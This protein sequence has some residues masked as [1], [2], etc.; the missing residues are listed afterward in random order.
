MD[1]SS[2][3]EVV[4]RLARH[5]LPHD[6]LVILLLH[7]EPDVPS[8][9]CL[10][11]AFCHLCHPVGPSVE[12]GRSWPPTGFSFSPVLLANQ[13]A[14][15]EDLAATAA[16]HPGDQ[17]LLDVG[18]AALIVPIYVPPRVL[19]G[20]VFMSQTPS[21]FSAGDVPPA[22]PVAGLLA[23]ALEHQRLCQQSKALAVA[24]ERNRLARDIHDIQAQSLT[25]IIMNL[26]SLKPY[27][28]RHS[29]AEAQMLAE[30][31]ALARA[32]LEEARRSI[33]RLSPTPLEYQSLRDALTQELARLAR[34][35]GLATQCY[36]H[37]EERPLAPDQ[38]TALFRVA[39]EAFQNIYKHAAARHVILGLAF[40]ADAVVLTIE[41]D[42]IG[43]VA[44]ARVPDEQGGFGLLSMAA[45]TRSLGGQLEV[46]SRPGHGTAVRA[47]LPYVRPRPTTA[48]VVLD[49]GEM[50]ATPAPLPCP[51]RVLVVD[52]HTVARQGIRR[53][54]DGHADI[55]VIG[56]AGDGP[57]AVEQ[58]ACLRPDVV[59]LDVQL[60][61][62]S[63][64][65]ALPRLR[66]VHPR[67][68]VVML[69]MFDNDEQVFASLKAGA[70]GYLLKDA[71]PETFVAA[72]R[73][74]SRGQSVL[75]PSVT[76]RVVDRFTVLAQRDVDP[77]ALTGRELE[78]LEC[79]AG[80]LRYKE[81]AAQLNITT[82][83]VQYHVTNI[84]QKLRVGSRG[85]A[86]AAAVERGLIRQA[87]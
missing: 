83:T 77:D 69:T 75:P 76:T 68:E 81:I 41:D 26:E 30:T 84:L 16:R 52:D 46:S 36:I 62:L 82:K 7:T 27:E 74:A 2:I 54:L 32:A 58:T 78:I 48:A 38:A 51:I 85:A 11:V 19:G 3:F 80:G 57:A 55:E 71:A 9:A 49:S 72:V 70:R 87:K 61:R 73:A 6:T 60:P 24:E 23:V 22:E 56:E 66:A 31:E 37:G 65:E 12:A 21:V 17:M 47:T 14:V 1:V 5:V 63:G 8:E 45:R 34:R 29:R 86:V 25:D 20:L 13:P 67:V 39:Q 18:R 33:L 43:F 64:I 42:G 53:I 10:T 44:E 79:M 50:P 4:S 35:A 59:L 40:E 15:I 28:A